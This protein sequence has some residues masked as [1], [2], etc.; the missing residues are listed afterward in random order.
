MSDK[1]DLDASALFKVPSMIAVVTGGGTGLG[2]MIAK[3]LALNGAHKVYILGR[4]LAKL[5]EAAK[6]SPHENIL[7]LQCDVTSKDELAAA[8][9]H[10]QREDGY[11]NLIAVNSGTGGPSMA[12]V[13]DKPSVGQFKDFCWQWDPQEF[14]NTFAV[15]NTAAFFTSIAFLELLDAGNKR[16]NVPGVSSQVIITASIAAYLRRVFSGFAY[17]MSKAAAAS[18]AKS[19]STMLAPYG[20]RCNAF[21]PGC[22]SRGLPRFMMC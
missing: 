9:V 12:G 22:E 7:P 5:Q 4:R 16:G 2:L 10:I 11:I 18:L 6:A 21:A 1:A 15:N 3:A 13:P 20:I 19:L 8:A 17:V 14:N